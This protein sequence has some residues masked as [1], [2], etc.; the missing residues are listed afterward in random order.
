[1]KI[2]DGKDF[3]VHSDLIEKLLSRGLTE[4]TLAQQQALKG[5]LV[6]GESLFISAPTSGGKTTIAEIAAVQTALKG[7]KSVYLLSHKALAEEKYK[8]FSE[9]YGDKD[10][11]WFDVAISTG[12]RIEG[13]WNNGILV[14]TYEKFLSMV[15]TSDDLVIDGVLVIADEIQLLNDESRGADV[16][17]L[18]TKIKLSDPAQLICLSATVNNSNELASWIGATEIRVIERDVPLS[19]QIWYQGSG[20]ECDFGE[21]EIKEMRGG[22]HPPL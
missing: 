5:G 8:L 10:D 14:A 18:C 11:K 15:S 21:E 6:S 22:S 12:D 1:M 2:E 4:F 9:V 13:G 7:G 19:Q 20:F 17:T 3:G 16:E